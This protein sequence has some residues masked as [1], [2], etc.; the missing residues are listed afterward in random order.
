MQPI[1]ENAIKHGLVEHGRSGTIRLQTKREKDNIIITV[2]DDGA[3]FA[4]EECG[5]EDSVGIKNVRYR[6]ENMVQGSLTIE[7]SPGV[8]TKVTISI[9]AALSQ[10]SLQQL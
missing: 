8:G 1:V 7:S 2:T 4:P 10:I 3:G 9:P 5:K 6:L